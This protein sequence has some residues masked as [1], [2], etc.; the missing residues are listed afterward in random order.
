MYVFYFKLVGRRHPLSIC[1]FVLITYRPR[2]V[3]VDS[4]LKLIVNKIAI[5]VAI[6]KITPLLTCRPKVC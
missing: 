6:E 5:Y 4:S 3:W 1:Q 2:D